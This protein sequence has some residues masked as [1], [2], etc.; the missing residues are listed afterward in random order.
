MFLGSEIDILVSKS[1]FD[2]SCDFSY[3]SFLFVSQ[4]AT[5]YLHYVY[6]M[7]FML[8]RNVIYHLLRPSPPALLLHP[9]LPCLPH[10]TTPP[11]LISSTFSSVYPNVLNTS[12]VCCPSVG[13]GERIPGVLSE[14]LTGVLTSLMGPQVGCSTSLTIS[15]ASTIDTSLALFESGSR[16]WRLRWRER[17]E[18]STIKR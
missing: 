6:S 15:L 8:Y 3:Q 4:C 9:S 12:L 2:I 11:F 7:I 18:R 14:N 10:V 5:P 1:T 16:I 13:G 17:I